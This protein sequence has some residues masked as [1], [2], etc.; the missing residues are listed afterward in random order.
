AAGPEAPP[1][2][3]DEL[4][5]RL[6]RLGGPAVG[7]IQ[8]RGVPLPDGERA[9]ALSIPVADALGWLVAVAGGLGGDEVGSSLVWLGRVAVEAVRMVARGAILP[10]L[11][12]HRRPDGRSLDL[13]VRWITLGAGRVVSELPAGLIPVSVV[14]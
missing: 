7:W 6:E 4:S 11:R 9:A 3:Q 12:T 2:G 1:A 8:H 13:H 10:V 14:P 5:E